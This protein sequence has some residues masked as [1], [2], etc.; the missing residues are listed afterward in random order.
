[1][2]SENLY[3]FKIYYKE[4]YSDIQSEIKQYLFQI[5]IT[6]MFQQIY[7]YWYDFI[8]TQYLYT[9]SHL[10]MLPENAE[11]KTLICKLPFPINHKQ[12]IQGE[13]GPLLLIVG[14]YL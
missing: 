6:W 5:N 13:N 2:A 10:N 4:K 9:I 14:K 3:I 12:K 11:C 7:L 8:N 1:M